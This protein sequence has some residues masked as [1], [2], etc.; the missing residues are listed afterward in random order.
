MY[1]DVH[2]QIVVVPDDIAA[3]KL[4]QVTGL[5]AYQKDVEVLRLRKNGTWK[6]IAEK[7]VMSVIFQIHH[8]H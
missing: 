6:E 1:D 7:E 3:G 2:C 4:P 5:L 8:L